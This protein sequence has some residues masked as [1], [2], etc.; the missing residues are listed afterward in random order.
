MSREVRLS[1]RVKQLSFD[2]ATNAFSLDSVATGF[3]PFKDFYED[4]DVVFYAATDGVRYEVGSGE[5]NSDTL[6]RYPLRSSNISAGPFFVDGKSAHGAT[7]GKDGHFYP[8]YL[9]KSAASGLKGYPTSDVSL[10]PT[11]VHEHRF[12]GFPGV[13]F[14]MPNNHVAHAVPVHHAGV[15]GENYAVSGAAVSFQGV[16][17]VFVTYPAKYSVFTGAGVSG[18]S[19][20]KSKGV[21]FWGNEQTLDY[22]SNIIWD[23]GV[24]SLGISQPSPLHPVD[25]GGLTSYSQVRASGFIGGG[26]GVAF[27]GGQALPQSALKTASGGRQLEPFF[28]SELDN[29]TKTDQVFSLSGLVGERLL[30][31]KQIKGS[32]FAGPA[33]GCVSTCSPDYPEFRYLE[34]EDVPDLS[35]LYVVQQNYFPATDITPG[36]VAFTNASGKIE[37]GTHFVFTKGSN[38]LGINTATP[39]ATLDVNGNIKSSGDVAISGWLEINKGLFVGGNVVASGNVGASGWVEINKGLSVG[40]NVVTS[41]DVGVSGWVEINK[42]LSVGGNVVTS[43]DVGVSG[44]VEINKGLSV[45]GNVVVSGSLDVQGDVT[46]IDSTQVTLLDKQLELASISGAAVHNHGV[47]DSGG[48]ILKSTDGDQFWIYSSG[49]LDG[50]S[51]DPAWVTDADIWTSGGVFRFN[52]G[53]DIS[54]AYHAGS[55]LELHNNVAFNVGNLFQ[56]SGE[57]GTNGRVHQGDIVF[58]SGINGIETSITTSNSIGLLPAKAVGKVTI[59]AYAEL[60]STDKVNLVATD[61]TNYDFQNGDHS[62]VAGTWS[63][64]TSNEATATS[65]MNV[66]NTSSGPAGT[67]FSASVVGAVVTITQNTVGLAGNTTV[68]LTD[69]GTAGMTKVDF[70]GGIDDRTHTVHVDP[71]HLSGVLQTQIISSGNTNLSYIRAN[72]ASGVAIS[73]YDAYALSASGNAN[74]DYTYAVSGWVGTH[75]AGQSHGGGGGGGFKVSASGGSNNTT[76]INEAVTTS[77]HFMGVSGVVADYTASDNIM[78]FAAPGL[79]GDLFTHINNSGNRAQYE[80][81]LYSDA[82]GQ[83]LKQDISMLDG[84]YHNWKVSASGGLNN[85]THITDEINGTQGVHFMGLS[86]V[87]ADYTA[88]T[89]TF[90]FAAP[91]LSA[92]ILSNSASGTAVL[93]ELRTESA[94]GVN[95]AADIIRNSASGVNHAADIIRNAASG[96]ATNTSVTNL[97]T[98]LRTESASGVAI[99]GYIEGRVGGLAGGYAN[100]KVSASGGLNNATHISDVVSTLSSVHFMGVSGFDVDYTASDNIMRFSDGELSG[101]MQSKLDALSGGYVNWKVSASGGANYGTAITDNITAGQGVHFM[102][103]SGVVAD[104]TAGTNTFRFAAPALSGY[105]AYAVAATGTTN[106][107]SA[108]T[109]ATAIIASGNAN[110]ASIATNAT[111]I[112]ASGNKGS[113]L[114]IAASLPVGSG[115]KIQANASDISTNA[116]AIIA[117]GNANHASIATNATAIIASGNAN[118]ASIATNATAIIAS[119][120]ANHASIATN[121]TAIIASGNVN[122]ASIATNATA[123]IASGNV[124]HASIATN[125]TAIIASGNANKDYT[126]AVSGLI[127]YLSYG[128]GVTIQSGVI[129]FRHD[130]SGTLKHLRF[131]N[132]VRIGEGAG[133]G[134]DDATLVS[135]VDS[136]LIGYHAGSGF[137][138]I[139]NSGL[140]SGIFIGS[141]AGALSSGQQASTFIGPYAGYDSVAILPS[142]PMGL[143]ATSQDYGYNIAIGGKSFFEASGQNVISIGHKAGHQSFI[144]TSCLFLGESAGVSAKH[145]YSSVAIGK[146]AFKWAN[147]FSDKTSYYSQAIGSR[148]GLAAD[149]V[150]RSQMIGAYAGA[151]SDDIYQ[152]I[153]I[154]DNAGWG[155]KDHKYMVLVG[156]RAGQNMRNDYYGVYLGSLAGAYA[157]VSGYNH[158]A[159]CIGKQAGYLLHDARECIYIGGQAGYH[160]SGV[161]DVIGIGDNAGRNALNIQ[162]SI[163]IGKDA[164]YDSPFVT[165]YKE[166]GSYNLVIAGNTEWANAR[167]NSVLEIGSMFHGI[168]RDTNHGSPNTQEKHLAIGAAPPSITDLAYKTVQIRPVDAFDVPLHL[169]RSNTQ[170]VPMMTASAGLGSHPDNHIINKWGMLVVPTATSLI[171][172][173]IYTAAG[174]L[175]PRVDGTV[176]LYNG[177]YSNG[178]GNQKWVLWCVGGVWKR[179]AAQLHNF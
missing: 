68:T 98:E 105:A 142:G 65:L 167:T 13:T 38:K 39:N 27:S 25:I 79:S 53:P 29:Q 161:E 59:T 32:I 176:C 126:T 5:Y 109:N 146:E 113:A 89:N 21:A 129:D 49:S 7:R 41:G 73:G 37:F 123:I 40:G 108:A 133:V 110:H 94:S 106:A 104:Y 101:V 81:N 134:A 84:G 30:L 168:S 67:R 166:P 140:L 177:T 151:Y 91:V 15:S 164:G 69:T 14:Y 26:S 162:D 147:Y 77:V 71:A 144:N 23:T 74:K 44:W 87:I 174:N 121:A 92:N 97:T 124:N 145:L 55:G 3:S 35:S 80:A 36:A 158:E 137:D 107:A 18:F 54:G 51:F 70:A 130:G 33:S 149:N 114:A 93:A 135:G 11:S 165:G 76:H 143:G 24:D 160:V 20:P 86:G 9:T 163:F 100:W 115:A 122:H 139:A 57:D 4:G 42:G 46:Y 63:S 85:A 66:I 111:A 116:T 131:D 43:G 8:L 154:G 75:V 132:D 175:V 50:S 22:D 102:G 112:I 31:Q 72:S 128:S 28:R 82:S 2:P 159:I 127:P 78:R 48:V 1:D 152:S 83:A 16:T 178:T 173:D 52:H 170:S 6:T 88:G 103:L 99:S 136:V 45:G 155:S 172:A 117:S 138:S 90:R 95:H 148:A 47:L 179:N 156:D 19:E 56:V 125:A 60:N 62:S 64:A 119:G 58:V 10:M 141:S 17:E 169:E 118:H 34:L 153:M 12:S 61:G 96:T 171:G 120:N 157:G 150:T